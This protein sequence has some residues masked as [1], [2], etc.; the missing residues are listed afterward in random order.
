MMLHLFQAFQMY[1]VSAMQNRNV[2]GGIKKILQN[3]IVTFSRHETRKK[4]KNT[5]FSILQC[6]FILIH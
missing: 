5:P 3:Q 4:K 6:R 1:G 2:F